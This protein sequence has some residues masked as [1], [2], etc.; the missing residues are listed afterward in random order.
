MTNHNAAGDAY[1]SPHDEFARV[2]NMRMESLAHT[3]TMVSLAGSL[4]TGAAVGAG[5][6]THIFKVVASSDNGSLHALQDIPWGFDPFVVVLI[7]LTDLFF[8]LAA[9]LLTDAIHNYS[10]ILEY[11]EPVMP[12]SSGQSSLRAHL[13]ALG[14]DDLSYFYLRHGLICLIAALLLC[15]P[16]V[17]VP[18]WLWHSFGIHLAVALACYG[19]ALLIVFRCYQVSHCVASRGII[20]EPPF[21]ESMRRF[22]SAGRWKDA[23]IDALPPGERR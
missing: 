18:S 21:A 9:F 12:S 1:R 23:A 7:V 11:A 5:A 4:F 15:A 8:L 3:R 17:F 13:R 19:A 16:N 14:A 22:L 2:I 6:T 20:R 10:K